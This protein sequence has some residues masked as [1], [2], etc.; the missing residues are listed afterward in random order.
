MTDVLGSMFGDAGSP[1]GAS[2]VTDPGM[3]STFSDMSGGGSGAASPDAGL[4]GLSFGGDLADAGAAA[5][6]AGA[7]TT[8]GDFGSDLSGGATST[9][10]FA[11]L[12][13]VLGGLFAAPTSAPGIDIG[14]T[15][16]TP[17]TPA[18][19]PVVPDLG[20]AVTPAAV[21][22]AAASANPVPNASGDLGPAGIGTGS[23][24]DAALGSDTTSLGKLAGG[25]PGMLGP[26]SAGTGGG[27]N[28]ILQ[29]L[30]GTGGSARGL[31][32][33][34]VG[35]G[36]IIKDLMSAGQLPKGSNQLLSEAGTQ[37]GLADSYAAQAEGEGQGL[38]PA[39]AQALVQQNLNANVAAIK[40]KYAQ[41]GMS[42][43][44]AEVQD[45]NAARN[46]SLAQTFAI[47]QSLAAQGLTEVSSASGLEAS[48]MSQ[49]MQAETAQNT[50]LGDA[51]ASFAGASVDG[52]RTPVVQAA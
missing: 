33:Q 15:A 16:T 43:S 10:P 11:G 1:G 32:P 4:G 46:A 50:Q 20:S 6:G 40:Q 36:A 52:G 37:K 29:T 19:T 49:I 48:I 26:A 28:N 27:G 44:S 51:L 12:G 23:G 8:G 31:L 39:G 41:L 9:N 7:G 35:G 47:G 25:Q 5:T 14:A 24:A 21:S 22:G 18:A 2:L 17:L 13:N 45:I 30:F 3:G 34:L 42:G 38:L